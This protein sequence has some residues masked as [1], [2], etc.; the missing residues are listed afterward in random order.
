MTALSGV[1]AASLTPLHPDLSPDLDRL[2]AHLEA[3]FAEGCDGAVLFGTTGEATSFSVPERTMVLDG[4]IA[5]GIDP[6]RVIVGIGCSAV[7]DTVALGRHA[8]DLDVAA[9]LVL[10]PFYYKEA[11]D[12]GLMDA[13]LWL[14][15][16]VPHVSVLLYNFPRVA[17]VGISPELAKRLRSEYPHR[18]AGVKDSSGDLDSL[19][20]FLAAMPGANVF[21]GTELLLVPGLDRGAVGTIS[22]MANVNAPRIRGVYETRDGIESLRSARNVASAHPLIPS[23]KA[24]IAARNDDPA[25]A[26]VRPP[27]RPLPVTVGAEL[28]AS[29]TA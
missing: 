21:P 8:A 5:R 23:L 18:V 28:A 1:W 14:L 15:D 20:A 19:T 17:G 22:A 11:S 3:L 12:D 13:F 2:A 4:V 24:V 29:L 9:V 7:P 25:W 16:E 6:G 26:T 27:F 10:P